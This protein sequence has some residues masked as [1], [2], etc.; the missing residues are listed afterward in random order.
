MADQLQIIVNTELTGQARLDD[1]AAQLKAIGTTAGQSSQMLQ[2]LGYSAAEASGALQRVGLASQEGAAGARAFGS[3]AQGA[4]RSGSLWRGMN[5]G[6]IGDMRMLRYSMYAFTTPLM[7]AWI[8]PEFVRIAQGISEAKSALEGL[9]EAGQKALATLEKEPAIL[10][11]LAGL[12]I[13][14][15][16]ADVRLAMAQELLSQKTSE[17]AVSALTSQSYWKILG[18]EIVALGS[19]AQGNAAPLAILASEFKTKATAVTDATKSTVKYNEYLQALTKLQKELDAENKKSEKS[20][21]GLAKA[22]VRAAEAIAVA[23]PVLPPY[24]REIE[25]ASKATDQDT[26]SIERNTKALEKNLPTLQKLGFTVPAG[27]PG[28]IVSTAVPAPGAGTPP[29]E[30][31][32]MRKL[33][34]SGVGTEAAGNVLLSGKKLVDAERQQA[35]EKFNIDAQFDRQTITSADERNA[36]IALAAAKLQEQLTAIQ[37][38][39]EKE[40]SK[41]EERTLNSIT[42]SMNRALDGWL[43]GTETFSMAFSRMWGSMAISAIEN[44][45]K[46]LVEEAAYHMLHITMADEE[47]IKDA[48]AAGAAAT[49]WAAPVLGPFAPIVGAAV[50]AGAMA[51]EHGGIVP[52]TAIA[53]VH[54]GEMVLPAHL[55]Q[56]VQQSAA[57]S[58]G[59]GGSNPRLHY[60]PTISA[61]DAT[62]VHDILK[63]H[64]RIFI[65][66]LHRELRRTNVM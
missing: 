20:S 51:F 8:A 40:R 6:I 32:V 39:G 29:F 3:A 5:T 59:R 35:M 43:Q 23:R 57:Q 36:K 4:V 15:Q 28:G 63:K 64:S 2:G 7:I 27:M 44:I 46:M 18:Q 13:K 41:A 34:L 11:Q 48:E 19:L 50:F 60:A 42:Q 52:Q 17:A 65:S 49:K 47:K 66:Q 14:A 38:K 54:Q 10:Q 33:A 21:D 62:G 26:L 55:S 31:D 45:A 56:F 53:K 1:L 12:P 9:D 24:I 61:V 30:P 22:Q 58:S 37:D 16:I 25:A